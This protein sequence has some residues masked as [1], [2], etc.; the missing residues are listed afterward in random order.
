MLLASFP[1]YALCLLWDT[2]ALLAGGAAAGSVRALRHWPWAAALAHLRVAGLLL[3]PTSPSSPS[4]G[5]T[6]TTLAAVPAGPLALYLAAEAWLLLSSLLGWAVAAE[7]GRRLEE[8]EDAGPFRTSGPKCSGCQS[9]RRRGRS[10]TELSLGGVGT[11]M[12]KPGSWWVA[13]ELEFLPSAPREED[14]F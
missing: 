2:A 7:C 1:C 11:T 6:T 5:P 8:D 14:F 3:S 4:G 13:E 9:L 12:A 10:R